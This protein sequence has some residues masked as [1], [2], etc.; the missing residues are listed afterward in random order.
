LAGIAVVDL[1]VPEANVRSAGYYIARTRTICRNCGGSTTVLALAAKKNHETLDTESAEGAGRW[2][3]A[4]N[5]AFLFY[6]THLSDDVRCRL[7]ALSPEFRLERSVASN[8]RWVN[9]CQH[10]DGVLD[11][12]EL[13]CEPGVFMPGCEAEAAE[14]ELLKIY[15][16]LEVAAAGYA[17]EPEFLQYMRR[18]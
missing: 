16:V 14:I 17:P 1:P 4:A 5:V 15:G 6:L 9:H 13:H 12:H 18:P 10:C 3:P 8:A 11:D 2:Q 7:L